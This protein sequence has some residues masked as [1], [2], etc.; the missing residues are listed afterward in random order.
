[1]TLP[2]NGAADR[3][4]TC[5]VPFRRRMPH[6]FD[7]GSIL[8][9]SERQDFHLR[10]PGP[11]PG[12]LKTELHSEKMADPNPDASGLNPPAD[13]PD[14]SGLIELRVRNGG[15]RWVTLQF[16]TSDFVF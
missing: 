9:W 10:P 5:I 1:M 15:K 7:H 12:A 11:K 14:K 13:N 4:P 3:I 6:V 8:K 2:G 16:V